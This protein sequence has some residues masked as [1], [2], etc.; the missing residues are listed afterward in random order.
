MRIILSPMIWSGHT[1][2]DQGFIGRLWWV[3][4]CKWISFELL[5]EGIVLRSKVNMETGPE[6]KNSAKTGFVRISLQQTVVKL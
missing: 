2:E 5:H 4:F 3:G 1:K 6:N